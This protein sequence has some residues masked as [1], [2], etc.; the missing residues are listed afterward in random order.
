[1]SYNNSEKKKIGV[2]I[3]GLSAKRGWAATAHLPALRTWPHDFELRALSASTLES[4]QEAALKHNVPLYFANDPTALVARPEVDLVVVSVKVPDHYK[5]VEAALRAGKHVFCEWPLGNGL[6]EALQMEALAKQQG[7]RAFVGLQIHAAPYARYL[8]DLIAS[9]Y[10]GEVLSTT[11]VGSSTMWGSTQ[12]EPH[13]DYLLDRSNGA[14]FLSIFL[15]HSLETLTWVLGGEFRELSSTLANRRPLVTPR[16]GGSQPPVVKTTEDQVLIQGT[17]TTGAVAS[18]HFRAG[19]KRGTGLLWII[20]GTKG[21]IEITNTL[22]GN[23]QL[24]DIRIR[25]AT[26][27]EK[28]LVELP[29]PASYQPQVLPDSPEQGVISLAALYGDLLSDLR[30]GTN[31]APTF[32]TAVRRHR[33]LEAVERASQTGE[34]QS[35]ITEL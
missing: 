31:N 17:L 9:G 3:I 30:N 29:V 32:S 4:A 25:G 11:L 23:L 34:R 10:V 33:S 18:V 2:G 14:T 35:Y 21:D 20:N 1:M 5:I 12:G 19:V 8:R 27:D 15:G 16:G 22:M 28:E 24:G 7:V 6:Q 26:G 13:F